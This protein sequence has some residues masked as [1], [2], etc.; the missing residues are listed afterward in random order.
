MASA[1]EAGRQGR[2][3]AKKMDR[4]AGYDMTDFG[5]LDLADRPLETNLVREPP[6]RTKWIAFGV[7]LLVVGAV[8]GYSW[9]RRPRPTA[10]VSPGVSV[11]HAD[12]SLKPSAAVL[13]GDRIP[14]PPLPESD[15]LVRELVVKLS[16]H[17]QVLAWLTTK[18]L[19]ENV[20]VVIL[21]ISEEQTPIA[22]IQR[23]APRARFKVKNVRDGVY[24]D[25]VSYQRYDEYAA[26]IG[27]LDPIGTARLYL[28]LKPRILDAYRT[29]G[30][31]EDD[32]NPVLERAIAVLLAVPVVD[33]DIPLR[34]KII[35][36]E[37]VNQELEL[38]SAPQKQLLRMGPA[39][40]RIVQG[41]LREIARLL[42]LHPGIVACVRSSCARA[43]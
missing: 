35:S 6:A 13:E 25:P 3:C 2:S 27:G 36:Y 24:L 41:K 18:G 17:P 15:P 12:I 20:A 16:S 14:L 34:E 39:N 43:G 31:P 7:M 22:H 40:I 10:P 38:L 9:L 4:Q 26:A 30:H 23:L 21:N 42:D 32:F 8:F 5:D 33:G 11:D 37:F 19:I 28:T 29:L 1:T